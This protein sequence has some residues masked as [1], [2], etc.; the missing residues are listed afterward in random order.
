[1]HPDGPFVALTLPDEGVARL[2]DKNRM[3]RPACNR[4]FPGTSFIPPPQADSGPAIIVI[5]AAVVVVHL[6]VSPGGGPPTLFR[7]PAPPPRSVEPMLRQHEIL[8]WN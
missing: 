5:P 1:M 4:R 6:E 3:G 8:A 2:H 7:I